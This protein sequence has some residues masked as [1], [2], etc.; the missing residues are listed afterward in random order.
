MVLAAIV[1]SSTCAIASSTTTR[2]PSS[3]ATRRPLPPPLPPPIPSAFQNPRRRPP[4]RQR[5][6]SLAVAQGR[7]AQPARAPRLHRGGRPFESGR[8]HRSQLAPD[9]PEGH[10]AIS[11]AE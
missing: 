4:V 5:L 8:A 10:P 7:V 6:A 9:A 11:I 1:G 2:T 3:I